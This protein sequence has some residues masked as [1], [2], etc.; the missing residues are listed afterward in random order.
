MADETE[1]KLHLPVTA[2]EALVQRKPLDSAV[3]RRQRLDAI[4][5]DTA[6]R[7]LQRNAMALRLRRSGRRWVQTLK[8]AGK[9]TGGLSVRGEWETPAR[10][11]GG[12][13][14]VNLA[15]LADTPLPAVLAGRRG[16]RAL[17]PVFRMRFTRDVRT[18]TRGR[19][20]IEV[21]IDR[22]RIE[23]LNAR[24]RRH[25]ELNEVEFELKQGQAEDLSALALRLIGRGRHALALVPLPLSKAERGY[26]LADD[27]KAP[28]LK[29]AARGFVAGLAVDQ[30]AGAALRAITAHGLSVLLANTE[31][32]QRGPD[33]EYVHQ[34]RVALRRMRSALR[35]LDRKHKDFPEALADELRWVGT[36]LGA[37]RDADV[38]AHCTLPTLVA[39]APTAQLSALST[40]VARG[41]MRRD[42]S[43][44][45]VVATLRRPR[46][47]QLTLRLQA[48]TLTAPPDGRTL[49]QLA[50]RT[51][52]KTHRR[53]FDEARF[54][55]ALPPERRHHVRILA[56]RLRYALDVFSVALPAKP[57]ETYI[58]ALSEL[59]DS[60]GEMNDI[61]VAGVA[62]PSLADEATLLATAK[63]WLDEREEESARNAEA[64]LLALSELQVPWGDT[65]R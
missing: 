51:L 13:P 55:A 18:V 36:A 27:Q 12:R 54:F 44:A 9:V 11:R 16:V 31:A 20:L 48:W 56:K 63:A 59:Q 35:L 4:Y 7:L 41:D 30:S 33:D 37:A 19:S 25:E 2:V 28:P 29:A 32:M 62:L 49:R 17:V 5:L 26:L 1:L 57:T 58:D 47:A 46:Y 65:D 53:L 60:L 8:S 40:L 61:A 3:A 23:T 39:A 43:H 45:A 38:L 64:R 10:M 24:Q 50:A 6:D 34:A 15:A 22:G 14:H 52:D 21:A 42:A